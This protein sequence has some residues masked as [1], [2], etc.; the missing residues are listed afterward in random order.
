MSIHV[1]WIRVATVRL[2]S[3]R[4]QADSGRL[5]WARLRLLCFGSVRLRV[6]EVVGRFGSFQ[7]EVCVDPV[8]LG[9]RCCSVWCYA[10]CRFGST[11]PSLL[12]S[13]G[14][15]AVAT[16]MAAGQHT[17]QTKDRGLGR[18]A[19]FGKGAMARFRI[20]FC[21]CVTS[22]VGWSLAGAWTH[23]LSLARK[24]DSD[25]TGPKTICTSHASSAKWAQWSQ[26]HDFRNLFQ[27]W[28][29]S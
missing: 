24:H 9:C 20:I 8:M 22:L 28:A 7:F 6:P 25:E 27:L 12:S 3:V 1:H 15:P 13:N 18:H 17:K 29:R 10:T 11:N 26:A 5:D 16:A 19:A 4:F 23:N 2:H 21:A 14:W